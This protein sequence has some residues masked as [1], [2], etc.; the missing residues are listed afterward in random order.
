MKKN[1]LHLKLE[2]ILAVRNFKRSKKAKTGEKHFQPL[3]PRSQ[4]FLEGGLIVLQ[5]FFLLGQCKKQAN[6]GRG[7]G[8][9]GNVKLCSQAM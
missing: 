4:D 1:Q 5:V 7:G 3:A 9:W 6:R 2:C 8:W